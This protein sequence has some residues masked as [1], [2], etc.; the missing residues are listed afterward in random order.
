[1]RT[2][3]KAALL[4]TVLTTL[5]LSLPR[6]TAAQDAPRKTKKAPPSATTTVTN[7]KGVKGVKGSK[8]T[9][10]TIET[11]S[12]Q[13]GATNVNPTSGNAAKA[14]NAGASIGSIKTGGKGAGTKKLGSPLYKGPNV[15]V[16][17]S[18]PQPNDS[19]HHHPKH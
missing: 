6:V 8:G 5:L 10:G 7:P 14:G 3:S 19:A 17:P 13:F 12:F 16:P 2:I 1:M 9:K 18:A 11:S 15:V 4:A